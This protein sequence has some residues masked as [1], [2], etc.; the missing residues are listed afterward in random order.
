MRRTVNP[1]YMCVCLCYVYSRHP[2]LRSKTS[3]PDIA[4]G[5]KVA[6]SGNGRLHR[7]ACPCKSRVSSCRQI[8]SHCSSKY[9]FVKLGRG[10]CGIKLSM[11]HDPSRA[12]RSIGM[13]HLTEGMQVLAAIG[14]VGHLF[15][16][17]TQWF[18]DNLE[19]NYFRSRIFTRRL[20]QGPCSATR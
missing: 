5:H 20:E 19:R 15:S 10:C 1:I 12:V 16:G 18:S 4:M 11:C 7:R 3:P 2:A 17:R 13:A 6:E 14:L 9:W 8:A